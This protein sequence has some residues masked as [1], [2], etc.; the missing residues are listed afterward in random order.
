MEHQE[1]TGNAREFV[2]DLDLDNRKLSIIFFALL[3]ICG[4]FFV[5]GY[6]LGNRADPPPVNYADAGTSANTRIKD[7]SGSE[8]YNRMNEIVSEQVQRSPAFTD[9][10]P[11]PAEAAVPVYEIPNSDLFALPEASTI[12]LNPEPSVPVKTTAAVQAAAVSTDKPKPP[13]QESP[14]LPETP[15]KTV[16]K[17]EGKTVPSA[18]QAEAKQ[19]TSA[20]VVY[21]VQVAAFRARGDAEATSMELE[22]KG[23]DSRIEPPQTSNDYYRIRVGRFA[24]REEAN[25]MANRLRRSGFETMISEIKGN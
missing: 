23:F 12:V 9:P 6:I 20:N 11:A 18:K 21:S 8:A 15:S 16:A 19:A 13:P 24:T 5:A 3:V 4:C 25:E 7:N 17:V 2:L 14:K 10:L 1:G 22:A